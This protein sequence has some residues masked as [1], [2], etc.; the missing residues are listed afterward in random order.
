MYVNILESDLVLPAGRQAEA[1]AAVKAR[2]DE[3]YAWSLDDEERAAATLPDFLAEWGLECHL[4]EAGDLCAVWYPHGGRKDRRFR[5]LWA[6]LAPFI[7]DGGTIDYADDDDEH[8]RL[9][10]LGGQV[11]E[12]AGEVAYPPP[13]GEPTLLAAAIAVVESWQTM[14]GFGGGRGVKPAVFVA[15]QEA[16][17]GAMGALERV[18]ARDRKRLA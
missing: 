9:Y 13:P 7:A 15:A 3:S 12:Q 18:V 14:R 5:E 16:A 10:F 1:L 11:H 17:T 4:S 6:T 8:W 2:T